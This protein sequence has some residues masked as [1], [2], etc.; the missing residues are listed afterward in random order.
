MLQPDL[1]VQQFNIFLFFGRF[2]LNVE[3]CNIFTGELV[4]ERVL[5]VGA[6][7]IM[8]Q[9]GLVIAGRRIDPKQEVMR[10]LQRCQADLRIIGIDR[11][12]EIGPGLI[13]FIPDE[14]EFIEPRLEFAQFD[15]LTVCRNLLGQF[16]LFFCSIELLQGTID[17]RITFSDREPP[18]GAVMKIFRVE[19]LHQPERLSFIF[20]KQ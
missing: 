13:V 6:R 2:V 4:L 10:I 1:A 20:R 12:L 14:V 19:Q 15:Q 11:G 7:F 17:L 16:K 9:G 5:E 3:F 8:P 18:A